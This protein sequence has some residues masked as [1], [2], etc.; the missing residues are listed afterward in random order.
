MNQEKGQAEE[1]FV[2]KEGQEKN[3]F[4]EINDSPFRNK[5]RPFKFYLKGLFLK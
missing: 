2:I 1:T 4:E 3:L 5:K